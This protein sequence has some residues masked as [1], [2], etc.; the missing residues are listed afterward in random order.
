MKKNV[1]ALA[2]IAALAA[3]ADAQ[4]GLWNIKQAIRLYDRALALDPQ[5]ATAYQQRGHR[6]LSIREFQKSRADLEKAASL[7]PKLVSVWYYLGVLDYS[8]GKFDRAAADFEKNL[9]LQDDDFTKAIGT[10]DWLYMSYR[11]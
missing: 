5:N 2:L 11:R 10:V 8:E 3:L 1:R 6:Q 7:D 4:A 9:A